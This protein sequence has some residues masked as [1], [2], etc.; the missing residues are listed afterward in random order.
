M[1]YSVSRRSFSYRYARSHR[2]SARSSNTKSRPQVGG[3]PRRWFE[4]CQNRFRTERTPSVLSD[5]RGSPQTCVVASVSRELVLP[6][7]LGACEA[8]RPP[9]PPRGRADAAEVHHQAAARASK[10]N[11]PLPSAAATAEG[12]GPSKRK[13]VSFVDGGTAPSAT[14]KVRAGRRSR[15]S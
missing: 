11:E 9:R 10:V 15:S 1:I 13:R 7:V 12:A 5:A 2:I 3:R 8:I 14:P 6:F 4:A